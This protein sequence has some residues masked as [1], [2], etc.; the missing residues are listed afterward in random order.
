MQSTLQ[1][2]VYLAI[3]A[4]DKAYFFLLN[5]SLSEL[6]HIASFCEFF[7]DPIVI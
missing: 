4:R 7:R 6:G 2:H 3:R 1:T 5:C